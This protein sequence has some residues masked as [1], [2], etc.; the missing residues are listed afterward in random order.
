MNIEIED[1]VLNNI[2]EERIAGLDTI[3]AYFKFADRVEQSK[4]D[5]VEILEH[6]KSQGKKIVSYGATSKSTTV[7]NYCQIT[8]ETIDYIVDITPSKQG[9]MSPGVHIPVVDY[10]VAFDSS[11]DVAFL[12]AWNYIEEISN[13][14]IDF[15]KNGGEFITHVPSVRRITGQNV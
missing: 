6:I 11:V 8:P 14:E 9:K 13:K 5:L 12:G 7:F 10:A 3:S 15:L 4:K 1:S 2:S